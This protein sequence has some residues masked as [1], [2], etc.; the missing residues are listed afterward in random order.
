[1]D[2]RQPIPSL[3]LLPWLVGGAVA[4]WALIPLVWVYAHY[5][6]DRSPT[7][8]ASGAP[9]DELQ[10]MAWI[11][12]A[13]RN[14]L[15]SSLWGIAPQHHDFLRPMYTP[16]GV[17]VRLGASV[18]LAY[19]IWKPVAVV[20]LVAGFAPYVRRRLAG[21][22]QRAAALLLALFYVTPVAALLEWGLGAPSR[23]FELALP[24]NNLFPAGATW[25]QHHAAVA[26][27]LSAAF[28]IGL[29]RLL[30]AAR[31]RPPLALLAGVGA[32]GVVVAWLRPWQGATLILIVLGVAAW[33]RER[34]RLG[35]LAALCAAVALPL[36]YY[37]LLGRLDP[38]WREA[39]A[40]IGREFP[41]P[42]ALA[43]A[44]L[45][46]AAFAAVGVSRARLHRRRV[47]HQ[48]RRPRALPA[49]S[50]SCRL[51]RLR[52]AL[53]GPAPG[54]PVGRALPGPGRR[55]ERDERDA[56]GGD[57]A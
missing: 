47:R 16:S 56:R 49:H 34:R 35:A 41:R 54:A 1:M 38:A 13:G 15:S 8:A 2:P 11:V 50:A 42:W 19:L 57:R 10:C 46:L 55:A 21:G 29:E 23:E 17:L 48:S 36:V 40:L 51:A 25:G 53:R 45:P 32:A 28:V 7:G 37:Y 22:A 26:F 12:D 52:R 4:I 33:R 27:G 39:D 9:V 31:G 14:W 6:P 20:V 5:L 3:C 44:L 30:A 24:V 18:Q 43:A